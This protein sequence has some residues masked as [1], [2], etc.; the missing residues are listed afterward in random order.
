V[1]SPPFSRALLLAPAATAI[2]LIATPET[3]WYIEGVDFATFK[4]GIIDPVR[5]ISDMGG[6]SW[7][8]YGALACMD[9]VGGDSRKYV[10][11]LSM[12]EVRGTRHVSSAW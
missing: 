12:P 11:W 9:V 5:Y 4:R 10:R 8:S 7:R 3:K 6:K 1:L 2:K